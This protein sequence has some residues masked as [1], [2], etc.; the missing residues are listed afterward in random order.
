M[1]PF[2]TDIPVSDFALNKSATIETVYNSPVH[3]Y[4]TE[5]FEKTYFLITNMESDI[6]S[7]NYVTYNDIFEPELI[8]PQG[9]ST[10]NL[11]NMIFNGSKP[12]EGKELEILNKTYN[13]LLSQKPTKL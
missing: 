5:L 3:R 10:I 11:S 6:E 1:T 8:D 13:R 2:V 4:S 12:L 9:I 7:P